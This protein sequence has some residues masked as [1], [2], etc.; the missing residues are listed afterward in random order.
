MS[1]VMVRL[2]GV[3]VQGADRGIIHHL[4]DTVKDIAT[5]G[6]SLETSGAYLSQFGG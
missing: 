2:G 5:I 6:K 4:V 3:A 1:S